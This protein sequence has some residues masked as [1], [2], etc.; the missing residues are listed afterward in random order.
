[1][2]AELSELLRDPEVKSWF[3]GTFRVVNERNILTGA[4]GIKRPDRI[5]IGA[6][7][8]VVVDYKSGD[9][10]ADTY[11]YQLRSYIRELKNC[12]FTNVSGYIWYTKTNKRV[13][14]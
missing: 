4:N 7:G 14:I 8:V 3:D 1:M 10:E 9:V 5:M 2:V 6:D 12:G 13:A 11:K